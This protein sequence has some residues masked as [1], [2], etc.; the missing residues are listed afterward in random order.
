MNMHVVDLLVYFDITYAD[1]TMIKLSRAV[2]LGHVKS[3]SDQLRHDQLA[4]QV[5]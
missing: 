2:M 4:R 3:E 1:I 5:S